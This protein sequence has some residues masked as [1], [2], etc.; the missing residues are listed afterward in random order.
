VAL[1]TSA[2]VSN[3][4]RDLSATMLVVPIAADTSSSTSTTASTA[5]HAWRAS[6]FCEPLSAAALPEKAQ[7]FALVR[8]SALL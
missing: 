3:A 7:Q 6:V 2:S 8:A 4:V 1:A 5:D